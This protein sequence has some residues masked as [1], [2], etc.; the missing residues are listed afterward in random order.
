MRVVIADDAVL[1]RQGLARLLEE[2]GVEVCALVGDATSCRA[3][4]LEHH[5]DVAVLDVRMPPTFSGEGIALAE[6]LKTTSPDLGVLLL[7]QTVD[8]RRATRLLRAHPFGL[9]YLLKDRV[10]DVD[11]LANGLETVRAGGSVLDPEVV[12]ALFAGRDARDAMASLSSRELEVLSR[13]AQGHSNAAIARSLVVN[14]RTIE[15]H[16]SRLM[17]KLDLLPEADTHRRVLAVIAYL[18]DGPRTAHTD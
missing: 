2:A 5:P 7:S 13:M 14:E 4:V 9:G 1:W 18:Q 15:S 12:A 11:T 6:E 16:I 8:V 3:A 17:T 10:L